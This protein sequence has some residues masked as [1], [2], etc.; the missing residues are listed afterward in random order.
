MKT[1]TTKFNAARTR[2]IA[3]DGDGNRVAFVREADLQTEEL[4][5]AAARALC[6]KMGWSGKLIGGYALKAG[7]TVARVW[8]W[9]DARSLR[10]DIAGPGAQ[11]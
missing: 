9:D 2:V 11:S 4:H 5:A 1:I 10:L 3:D 7:A 6:E 8:V